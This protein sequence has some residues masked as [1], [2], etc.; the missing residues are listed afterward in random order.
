VMQWSEE[1]QQ[2]TLGERLFGIENTKRLESSDS[3]KAASADVAWSSIDAEQNGLYELKASFGGKL[4]LLC[5]GQEVKVTGE[6]GNSEGASSEQTLQVSDRN[7]NTAD[8]NR[9]SQLFTAELHL[10]QG[11]NHIMFWLAEQ[12]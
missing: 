6:N 3:S 12:Y 4:S 5:N 10:K 2:L 9:D 11:V 1:Q 7:G 8:A